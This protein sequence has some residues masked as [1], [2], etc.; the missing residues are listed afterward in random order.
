MQQFENHPNKESFLQ[1]LT[2]P[3]K[4]N[5]FSERS[6]KLPTW[7]HRYL[8][9]L[10]NLC[11]ETVKQCPDCNLYW[12]SGIVYCSCGK[13]LKPSQST[14][15]LDKKN[16]DALSIP[17]YVIKKTLHRGAKHGASERQRMYYNTKEMLQ[18]TRQAW[19]KQDHFGKMAQR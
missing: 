19:C 14:K 1:D 6:K 3:E 9:A 2:K 8:R 4:I 5:A 16:L 10:R 15:K 11:Q 7:Q 18:K 17:G 13:S 12:E